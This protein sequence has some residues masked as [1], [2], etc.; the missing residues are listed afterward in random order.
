MQHYGKKQLLNQQKYRQMKKL[1]FGALFAIAAMSGLVSCDK[2]EYFAAELQPSYFVIADASHVDLYDQQ[3]VLCE[4]GR[5]AEFKINPQFTLNYVGQTP[6]EPIE[7]NKMLQDVSY[8]LNDHT[9]DGG[10]VVYFKYNHFLN[11]LRIYGVNIEGTDALGKKFS[12]YCLDDVQISAEIQ[13][14]E[15]CKS[16]FLQVGKIHYT[17]FVMKKN[18]KLILAQADQD[19]RIWEDTA[20][21]EF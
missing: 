17:L 12:V 13:T 9:S 10:L 11:M 14:E 20:D 15:T 2:D 16:P 18:E 7:D 19:F 1:F 3:K 8:Y 5:E 4:E 6:L 21:S